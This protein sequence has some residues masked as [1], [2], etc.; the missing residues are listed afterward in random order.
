MTT[1]A[2]TSTAAVDVLEKNLDV[3]RFF[4]KW[5]KDATGNPYFAFLGLAD[6]LIVTG[7]SMSMLTEACF[8]RKP[9]YIFDL[10]EGRNAMR[11]G[12]SSS[13]PRPWREFEFSQLRGFLY[14][15]LMRFGPIR[16]S[17]D[18]RIIHQDLV[19]AKRAAWLGETFLIDHRPPPL[20]CIDHAVAGVRQLFDL[21]PVPAYGS[22][23]FAV[24]QE[25]PLRR[26]A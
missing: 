2:R 22:I 11:S 24:P 10:G 26:S 8:T 19:A 1:S 12:I 3:P 23:P 5:A 13:D 16:L 14:S 18:I 20:D 17:R 6:E 9:V 15:Q 25:E 4:F 21:P 7:D